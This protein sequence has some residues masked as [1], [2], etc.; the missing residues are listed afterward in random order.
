M[1]AKRV[2]WVQKCMFSVSEACHY[3]RTTYLQESNLQISAF[4]NIT[5]V[6]GIIKLFTMTCSDGVP[7]CSNSLAHLV[8]AASQ[9]VGEVHQWIPITCF[10]LTVQDI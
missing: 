9:R 10:L 8:S 6:V 1:Q 3:T 2:G 7:V 5:E 4:S